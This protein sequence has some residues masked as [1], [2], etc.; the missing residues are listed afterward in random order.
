MNCRLYIGHLDGSEQIVKPALNQNKGRFYLLRK[1]REQ[2]KREK[3][4]IN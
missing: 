3:E 4:E 1:D 2:L